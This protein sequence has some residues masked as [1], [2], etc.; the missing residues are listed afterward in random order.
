MNFDTIGERNCGAEPCGPKI[1][2]LMLSNGSDI[3]P[4][5]AGTAIVEPTIVYRYHGTKEHP[6]VAMAVDRRADGVATAGHDA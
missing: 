1:N 2:E 5:I 6:E 3:A 4:A